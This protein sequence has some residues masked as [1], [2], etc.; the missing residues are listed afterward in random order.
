MAIDDDEDFRKKLASVAT[1]E[2]VDEVG[3]LWLSRPDG[4]ERAI[5]DL[6][7]QK[8]VD[9]EAALRREEK[10]RLAAQEAAARGH[11]ELLSARAE[12]ERERAAKA[13]A[14]ADQDRLRSELDDV[15][16]RLREAQRGE[17]ATG[18][19]LAKAESELVE[20]RRI[21]SEPVPDP[22][23]VID[24]T[25]VRALINDAVAASADA[26]APFC[27]P[28]STSWPSSMH[29]LSRRP[30]PSGPFVLVARRFVCREVCW[31]APSKPP[32]SSCESKALEY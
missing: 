29:Q 30:R 13:A 22:P 31:S 8:P 26:A 18:Q 19:S 14:I 4:W 16:A 32:S 21:T 17:H 20:L 1:T 25:V 2:L 24:A 11:A 7:P 6:L 3:V 15:R 28:P 27:R 9:D 5:I 12:L 10:R 23:P